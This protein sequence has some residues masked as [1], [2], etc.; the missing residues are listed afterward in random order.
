MSLIVPEIL[1]Q[2]TRIINVVDQVT[3]GIIINGT[4]PVT[5]ELNS[6]YNDEGATSYDIVWG[7]LT[8]FIKTTNTVNTKIVGTYTVTYSATDYSE[9]TYTTQRIVYV[10]DVIPVITLVGGDNITIDI[11][12]KIQR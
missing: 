5:I 3:P 6:V 1:I 4:Y 11:N 8:P 12:E 10:K 9:N 7:D 2:K